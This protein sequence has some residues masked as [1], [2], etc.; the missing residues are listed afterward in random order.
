MIDVTLLYEAIAYEREMEWNR[1]SL[2]R[3][4]REAL[5]S[6]TAGEPL[7]ARWRRPASVIPWP[8]A[9]RTRRKRVA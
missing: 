3:A 9:L 8:Q 6:Q 5:R 4:A 7:A 1:A 2:V